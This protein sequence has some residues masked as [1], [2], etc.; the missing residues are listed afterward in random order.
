MVAT[1]PASIQD[2]AAATGVDAQSVENTIL[3]L[4]RTYN[5]E[6]PEH[7]RHGFE[8]RQVAEG[9]RIYARD[10]YSHVIERFVIGEKTSRLSQAALETLAVVAYRQ[11]VTRGQISAIRGVNVDGVVRTLTA[12]GLIEETGTSESGALHYCTTSQFLEAFGLR[13][14]DDL[15]PMAPYYP[16]ADQLPDVMDEIESL[17]R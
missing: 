8:L 2:I 14:L 6:V 13:S 10:E 17:R 7:P 12:R 4:Q 9:W 3:A 1:E 11:P 5:G 16:A 15:P